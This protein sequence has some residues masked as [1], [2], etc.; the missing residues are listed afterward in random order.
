MKT[1]P[2][3]TKPLMLAVVLAA[4]CAV[5]VAHADLGAK[6]QRHSYTADVTRTAGNGKTVSRHTAQTA[7]AT[8]FNRSTAMTA[9]DGRTASRTVSGNRDAE[10]GTY[11]KS[12]NGTRLNGDTYSG[13][14][15]TQK[16]DDGFTRSSTRTNASGETASKQMSVEVDK[17]NGTL[18]KNISATGFNGET[19]SV[20]VVK[21][22]SKGEA[23]GSA[24]N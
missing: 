23:S 8:G 16:T 21:T 3:K 11:T 15:V 2:M 18:T 14:R 12:I 20:T 4:S 7:T 9:P 1:K 5:S 17:E 24:Q 13:E 10:A 6:H 22:Y 19:H